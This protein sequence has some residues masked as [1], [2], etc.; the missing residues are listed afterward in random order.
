MAFSQVI[1]MLKI[2]VYYDHIGVAVLVVVT[3]TIGMV[4]VKPSLRAL[5]KGRGHVRATSPLPSLSCLNRI[6]IR[7][8]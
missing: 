8:F 4:V 3:T 1:S 2:S 5:N 6:W 7:S